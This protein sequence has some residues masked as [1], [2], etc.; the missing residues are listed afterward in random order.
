[1]TNRRP[2]LIAIVMMMTGLGRL[3]AQVSHHDDSGVRKAE[4]ERE[5]A[6]RAGDTKA[7]DR[8]LTTD[9]LEV[10]VDG[11]LHGRAQ[12]LGL[13]PDSSPAEGLAAHLHNNVA[14]VIG[15]EGEMRIFR[16]WVHQH[17][18][19]RL[20]AQQA[21]RIQPG[22]PAVKP[23][24]AL[25]A[26]P[27]IVSANNEGP[28]VRSVLAAQTALD[29]ANASRDANAFESLTAPDFVLVTSHGLVR[30][31][32]DRVV[33]QRWQR[34]Q[35]LSDQ[36]L[37]LP[38]RDDVHVRVYGTIAVLTARSWSKGADGTPHMPTRFTRI[39]EKNP[40]GWQQVANITTFVTGP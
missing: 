25:L 1:M 29:R 3:P 23:S 10:N 21:V 18:Q 32:E 15:R 30:G 17:N 11:R 33:E 6:I 26:T 13:T 19:W 24:P 27:R 14:V 2:V 22:A 12:A 9:Y 39:W 35:E 28:V 16:V 37:P 36:P 4:A 31:K 40:T 5:A 7:L 34:L 38:E 20:A 8:L